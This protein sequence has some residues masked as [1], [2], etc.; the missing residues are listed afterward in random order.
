MIRKVILII[1]LIIVGLESIDMLVIRYIKVSP[2]SG[3][4][5]WIG[6]FSWAVIILSSVGGKSTDKFSLTTK[7]IGVVV[8]CL[9]VVAFIVLLVS[10]SPARAVLSN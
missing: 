4:L 8:A 1:A 6:T 5:G 3:L 10:S 9:Y 7:V 2:E